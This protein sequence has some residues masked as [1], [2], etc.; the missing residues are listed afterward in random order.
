MAMKGKGVV[1]EGEKNEANLSAVEKN[2]RNKSTKIVRV[3][4]YT[5]TFCFKRFYSA[6]AMGGH[7][8]AHRLERIRE[9][10]LFVRDPIGYRKR[11]FIRSVKTLKDSESSIKYRLLNMRV[12]Q[13]KLVPLMIKPQPPS[14][15][16]CSSPQKKLAQLRTIKPK[17]VS[18]AHKA[19]YYNPMFI[20]R[21][22]PTFSP[23][24]LNSFPPMELSLADKVGTHAE[25][26]A[27]NGGGYE[28]EPEKLDL[29]LKL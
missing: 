13:K 11:P 28:V 6:Q 1:V 15:D 24:Q 4:E 16:T 19:N 18:F 5:C 22:K 26:M 29:T 25:A 7:Q 2:E 14:G 9:K 21:K 8:N 20:I 3:Y 17:P 10:K 27:C 12:S 23:F